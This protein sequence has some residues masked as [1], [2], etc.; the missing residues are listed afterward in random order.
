MTNVQLIEPG[1]KQWLSK[2][3]QY[4]HKIHLQTQS[5][6]FN[7]TMIVVFVI[8]FGGILIYKYKGKLTPEQSY[9]KNI[10]KQEYI[11]SKLQQLSVL[12]QTI[13]PNRI[14]NLPLL[15]QYP[16]TSGMNRKLYI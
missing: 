4:Y 13:D 6:R 10:E 8:V 7:L 12:K 11:V 9:Q 15:E 14:T 3:L 16:E 5:I 2:T 1:V